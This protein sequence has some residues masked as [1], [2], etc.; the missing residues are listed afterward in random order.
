MATCRKAWW[1]LAAAGWLAADIPSLAVDPP[2]LAGETTRTAQRMAKAEELEHEWH[3]TEAVNLYLRLID[4][5]SDDLVP[6]DGG[7]RLVPA[8]DVVH[9]RVA[10]RTELLAPYRDRVEPRAKR[11]LERG[12]AD[13][14][15]QPLAQLVDQFFCARSAEAG[16]HLLGDLACARG[17]FDAARRYWHLLEPGEPLELAYPDPTMRPALARA[18][19]IVALLLAGNRADAAAGLADFRKA[20]G[21][22]IGHLAGRDGN[23]V[24]TLQHLIDTSAAVRVP[25]P[26]GIAPGPKTFGGDATRNGLLAGVLPPFSPQ[27]RYGPI[28]LPGAV[29]SRRPVQRSTVGPTTLVFHPVVALGQVFVA[30]AR[31]VLAYDLVTG[32]LSGRFDLFGPG[33]TVPAWGNTKLPTKGGGFTLTVNGD[34]VIARLGPPVLEARDGASVLVCLQWRPGEMSLADRLQARW[35]LGPPKVASSDAT[36]AWEGTPVVRDGR[37]YSAFARLGAGRHVTALACYDANDPFAGP[38]WQKDVFEASGDGSHRAGPRLLT[39]A[40]PDVIL[41]SHTGVIVAVEA[42]SGRWAWAVRY[43][44]RGAASAAGSIGPRDPAPCVAAGGRVYAAPADADRVF[45]YDAATGAPVWASDALE[46]GHLLGVVRGRVVCTLGGLHAGLCALD[47]ATGR[48]IPDWGYRV[49]GADALAPFGRGLLYDDRVYWPTRTA[50]VMELR[51]DGT[52]GY[53]P[54]AFRDLPGGNLAYG[55][56]SL[57][58]ATADRL[59][60]LVGAAAEADG[61]LNQVGQGS[62]DRDR[63]HSLLLWRSDMLRRSGQPDA[64]VRT[65]LDAASASE[66]GPERRFAALVRRAEFETVTG[67]RD[68]A[69]AAARTVADS[70]ELRSVSLRDADGIVWSARQW[71]NETTGRPSHDDEPVEVQDAD[72]ASPVT[73]RL[74][75]VPTWRVGLDRGREW[76]PISDGETGTERVFVAGRNWLA[77]RDVETGADRWRRDLAFAPSWLTTVNG[78]AIV[79]GH[80]GTA[81]LSTADGRKNWEFTVPPIAPWFDRAGWR[82][83]DAVARPPERL[84]AYRWAGGRVVARLGPRSLIALHGTTGAVLWQRTAP[85]AGGF[86]PSFFADERHVVAQSTDGR[87]WVFDAA[88]GRTL[89]SGPAPLDAWPNPPIALDHDRLV[90]VEENKVVVLDRSTWEPAWTR[91]LPRWPSL[92]G[93]SPQTRLV[94]GSLFVGVPRNDRYEIDRLETVRGRAVGEALEVARE[95]VDFA[96]MAF[97]GERL[98]VVVEGELRTIDG[99]FGRVIDRMPLAAPGPWRVEPV[100]DGMILWTAPSVTPYE[101][102]TAGRVVV[103]GWPALGSTAAGHPSGASAHS[104]RAAEIKVGRQGFVRVVGNEVVVASESEV[105]GYRGASRE[106]K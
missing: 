70:A 92:T 34:H 72:R 89:H 58:V 49:A 5:A 10:A 78:S 25:S 1:A 81:R 63:R 20:H 18:K 84:S 99:R 40:G 77:C 59:H 64:V 4:E 6:I 54:T 47:A 46:V 87:R 32:Q 90:V 65:A 67:C 45:C 3:W 60:V 85:F 43:P 75:L 13:R 93:A 66:F 88:T 29:E 57:V 21:N 35:T 38:V 14:D 68:G 8:R 105:R 39:L 26:I 17:E 62:D 80:G 30:D 97:D 33:D 11:L 73:L 44:P 12:E 36:V 51:W 83:P 100:R 24:A 23:L 16:L 28:A 61:P 7:G 19:Q 56:G 76:V 2:K 98:H 91:E 104:L 50:G 103:A 9:R 41:C 42:A 27:P 22:E 55:D 101:P 95:P 48:R 52:T 15:P 96:A 74:P 82:D 69:I 102:P 79:A 94:G 86:L 37:L 31:R 71:L 106:V 53:P